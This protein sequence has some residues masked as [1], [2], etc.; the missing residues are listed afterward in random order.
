MEENKS[1][2]E[3]NGKSDVKL[4]RERQIKIGKK[5]RKKIQKKTGNKAVEQNYLL[6]LA[7][8]RLIPYGP[9]IQIMANHLGRHINTNKV[10]RS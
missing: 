1:K 2:Y 10:Q 6:F 7:T 3:P 5:T 9:K 4:H 8:T